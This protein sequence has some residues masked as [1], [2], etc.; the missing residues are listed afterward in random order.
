MPDSTFL[1]RV[2]INNYKSI[3]HCDVN[4]GPLTFLVGRNGSG[5]SNFLDALQFVSDA[6]N[7]T[8]EQAMRD[9]GGFAEIVYR[10]KSASHTISIELSFK[11]SNGGECKYSFRLGDTSMGVYGV[12]DESCQVLDNDRKRTYYE[13]KNGILILN[14]CVLSP[15]MPD[16][17]YLIAASSDPAIRPAYDALS[18]MKFYNLNPDVMSGGKHNDS[19]ENLTRDGANIS[20]VV[21]KMKAQSP[22]T[23]KRVEQYLSVI[24]PNLS[25]V[26]VGRLNSFEMLEF[27][28]YVSD[29][30]DPQRFESL[31][32]S[33]GT[34]RSLGVLAALFQKS[35]KNGLQIPLVG[36]EEPENGLHPFAIG[37]LYDALT[38]AS[39]TRQVIVTTHNSE[40]LDVKD[41]DPDSILEVASEGGDTRITQIDSINRRVISDKLF[42]PGELL[43]MNQLAPFRQTQRPEKMIVPDVA[44]SGR[45]R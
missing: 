24:L 30:V 28:L 17:L 18:N 23:L 20:S 8:L 14:S 19:G 11:L 40:L 2:V 42:T 35:K 5:K 15:H 13:I 45:V 31:S 43:R 29:F 27:Y 33:D 32:M 36:I 34:L 7:N 12:L 44:S 37:A 38:D 6:L 39:E 1:T 25:H 41:I 16:R 4:L 21:A 26:D 9:R 3:Q 10:S 22:E